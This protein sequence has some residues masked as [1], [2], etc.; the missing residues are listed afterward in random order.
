[1]HIN[2]GFSIQVKTSSNHL[3]VLLKNE[4]SEVGKVMFCASQNPARGSTPVGR[5][6]DSLTTKI[7]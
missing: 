7:T 6:K 3:G 1:M 5:R 2:F 4:Q